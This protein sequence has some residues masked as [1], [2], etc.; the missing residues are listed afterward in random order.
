MLVLSRKTG[1]S[2]VVANSIRV[3]VVQVSGGS[4]RIGIDAPREVSILRAE[5]HR[6]I[7]GENLRSLAVGDAHGAALSQELLGR[8]RAPGNEKKKR[9][10][11]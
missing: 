3:T 6:E 11:R 5:L 1:E 4:V 9:P 10:P 7:E 2:I 8:L